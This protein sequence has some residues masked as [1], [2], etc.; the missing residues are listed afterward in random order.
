MS[1][2]VTVVEREKESKP[3]LYKPDGTPLT[4]PPVPFGFQPPTRKD[5]K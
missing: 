4:T 5:R 2:T 1:E 3:V